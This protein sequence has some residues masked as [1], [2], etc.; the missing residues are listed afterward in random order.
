ML[1]DCFL[2]VSRSTMSSSRSSSYSSSE[3]PS[4]TASGSLM[5]M[6]FSTTGSW[7]A[8]FFLSSASMLMPSRSSASSST[9]MASRTR[10]RRLSFWRSTSTSESSVRGTGFS[11]GSCTASSFSVRCWMPALTSMRMR[12]MRSYLWRWRSALICSSDAALAER[13]LTMAEGTRSR[14]AVSVCAAYVRPSTRS[15][16]VRFCSVSASILRC[17]SSV[18]C[19][20]LLC[21]SSCVMNF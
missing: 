6:L 20:R 13:G 10:R 7:S 8:E 17:D 5:R 16:S 9:R 19:C 2:R 1:M 14:A 12:L 15:W 18:I 21:V 3:T 4:S 11:P